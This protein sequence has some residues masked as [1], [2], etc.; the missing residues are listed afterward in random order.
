MNPLKQETKNEKWR[1]LET[2]IWF[3]T[4]GRERAYRI[5]CQDDQK[6][7]CEYFWPSV[8]QDPDCDDCYWGGWR[9]N[10]GWPWKSTSV[11][12]RTWILGVISRVALLG[13][14]TRF[15]LG[16]HGSSYV[17]GSVV[18]LHVFLSHGTFSYGRERGRVLKPKNLKQWATLVNP[19]IVDMIFFFFF[20]KLIA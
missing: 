16:D 8:W 14:P 11:C 7:V 13:F 2:W 19:F 5:D 17:A 6:K 1:E 12:K 9:W 20:C 15:L 4:C 10:W 18:V 3:Q